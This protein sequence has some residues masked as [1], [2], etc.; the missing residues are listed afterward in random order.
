MTAASSRTPRA[1]ILGLNYAPEPVGIGPYTAGVAEAFAATGMATDVVAA[2][3]YYPAWRKQAG[4][5]GWRRSRENG[6]NVLRCPIYVP[7]RPSGARR[8]IHH[9]SFALSALVPMLNAAR[10]RPDFVLVI[11][12]SLLSVPVAALAAR[13][14]GVPLWIHV[15]DFEA[16]AA[17]ATGLIAGDGFAAR[18]ARGTE[19]RLLGAGALVSTISQRMA[20]RLLAKGVA[21]SRVAELRNW[22]SSAFAQGDPSGGSYRTQWNLGDRQVALYSGNVANKQGID[23]IVEAARLLAHR[24]DIVFVICGEGP[25]RANLEQ[26]AAGLPNVQIHDLQPLDRVGDLLALASFHL[27][28]QIAGAADLVLPSKLANMLISGRPVIATAPADSSL[29]AEVR[30][31]GVVVDTGDPLALARAV[32]QLADDPQERA[33][34]GAAAHERAIARWSRDA[35]LAQFVAAAKTLAAGAA[36]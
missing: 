17:F 2:S 12:P 32:E 29:A 25:N 20:E 14:A 13:L 15:Q 16:E 18:L 24:P 23:I 31:A 7:R 30:G 36:A 4:Y 5:S 9:L 26:L 22:S 34:L 28:P 6:V 19:I 11:A 3:P 8:V 10:R 21:A 27:L 35:L 33:R 1:L